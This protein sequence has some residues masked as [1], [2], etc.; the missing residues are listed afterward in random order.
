MVRFSV[1]LIGLLVTLALLLPARPL[2]AGPLPAAPAARGAAAPLHVAPVEPSMVLRRLAAV[3]VAAGY[4]H[5]CALTSDGGVMC[6]GNNNFGQ[7]GDG[8]TIDRAAPGSV[9]GLTSGVRQSPPQPIT[10]AP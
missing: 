10:T 4:E 1:R 8:T 6:W 5:T 3:R 7:L 2:A 9:A